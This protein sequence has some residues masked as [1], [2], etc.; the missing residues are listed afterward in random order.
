MQEVAHRKRT[1]S[2]CSKITSVISG[3]KTSDSMGACYIFCMS[4][5][6]MHMYVTTFFI[7]LCISSNTSLIK[8]KFISWEGL[9]TI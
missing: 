5:K 8:R 6:Y 9:S 2:I 3:L 7:V 1:A 4:V